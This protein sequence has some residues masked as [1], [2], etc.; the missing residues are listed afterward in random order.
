MHLVRFDR[1]EDGEERWHALGLAAGVVLL[2]VVHTYP[3]GD[4][5]VI[6]LV[7]ARRATKRERKV[8]EHGDF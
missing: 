6:R 3:D 1:N 8:Y 5:E 7:S 4:D 2:I